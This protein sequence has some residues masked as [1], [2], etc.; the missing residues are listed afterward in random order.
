MQKSPQAEQD[1]RVS[2]LLQLPGATEEVAESL[3]HTN[4]LNSAGD[5]CGG[6]SQPV[7]CR[8]R[9]RVIG[10]RAGTEELAA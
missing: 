3:E 10:G 6:S 9:G 2:G 8:F 7:N 4:H 5:R 1:V